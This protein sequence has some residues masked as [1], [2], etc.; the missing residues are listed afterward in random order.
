MQ[1][2]MSAA[3]LHSM[4]LSDNYNLGGMM[5]P[6]TGNMLS[7]QQ[8]MMGMGMSQNPMMMLNN[9]NFM[10]AQI[11]QYNPHGFQMDDSEMMS[12]QQ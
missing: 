5:G 2:S 12:Q 8:M 3:H 9:P 1:M 11:P 7:Q 4:D 10:N 6:N